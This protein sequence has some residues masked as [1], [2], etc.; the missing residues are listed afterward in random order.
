V[1]QLP[2]PFALCSPKALTLC[3][4]SITYLIARNHNRRGFKIPL[5]D[6]PC[7]DRNLSVVTLAALPTSTRRPRLQAA[8]P[9]TNEPI[10]PPN[11]KE[12]G[13]L[14]SL[15]ST[16]IESVPDGPREIVLSSLHDMEMCEKKTAGHE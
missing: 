4:Y 9:Q 15:A 8:T 16:Q 13:E 3:F 7:G 11:P 14:T 5:E 2:K 12:T 6:R 10:W 1:W